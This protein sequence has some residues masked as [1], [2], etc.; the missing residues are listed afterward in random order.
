M[1]FS[2][3]L[4]ITCV[5]APSLRAATVRGT[6][7]DTSAAAVAGATVVLEN[8]AT[9]ERRS[10]T[11]GGDGRFAFEALPTGSY[12]LSVHLTGFSDEARTFSIGADEQTV[13]SRLTLRLGTLATSVTVTAT[14]SQRDS[15]IVPLRA[16]VLGSAELDRD[17]PA[18]T[19]DF[20]VR[21]PGVSLVGNGPFQVRPRLRGLDSTRLLVLIDGERLNNARTATDRAGVEVGLVDPSD[22]ERVEIVSGSGSVL[23]GTDALSGTIN[24][25]TQSARPSDAWRVTGGV[26]G[27]YST[28]ENARRGTLRAGA[29]GKHVA[30]S[31]SVSKERFGDYH[32]GSPFGESSV[33]LFPGTL[34]QADT[35]DDNFPP[36][37]FRAFPDPFN[38]PFTRTTDLVPNS[39]AEAS[40]VAATA[41]VEPTASQTVT[42]RYARRHATDVG[43]PDFDPPIFFQGLR[44]PF[45]NLD[46]WSAQY[47]VR[48][49]APWFAGLRATAYH[50]TQDRKL[51]NIGI[52][53]QFPVPTPRTFFPINVFR[54]L[55][56]TS[57]RQK[58]KTP[59]LDVQGTFL[60]SPRNVLIAG[61]T[62][63]EDRSDDSR[64]STTG[65]Y[66]AGNVSLG[67]RGPQANVFPEP[68][69]LGQSP[70]TFP[71]RVPD[72]TLR[73]IGFFVQDEWDLTPS[74][75]LVAGVRLDE[76][77]VTTEPTP[78]YDVGPVIGGAVPAIDQSTLPDPAGDRISRTAFTG[79]VGLVYKINDRTSF[80]AHYG[81][82]YRHP[83]LEE[84]LFAG[85]ATAGSI[86]PNIKVEP[87]KGDN[88]DFGVKVRSGR[89]SEQITYFRNTYR[90]LI[91]QEFVARLPGNQFLAQAV[92]FS[93]VRIQ[94]VEAEIE[95][96][97]TVGGALLTA[98]AS[99][100]YTHGKVIEA[101]NPLTGESLDGAPQD[102]ISPLK[103]MSGLRVSDR[104]GRVWAEYANRIQKK[105][106]RVSPLLTDSPFAIAQ[107]YLA[108][109][110]FT[111]HRL[112]AGIDWRAGG[113][114][115]G[116]TVAAE[117]IGDRFYREQFQFAPGRGR[118]FTFGLRLARR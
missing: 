80:L 35:I 45:S 38:S 65:T 89:V 6:V 69:F 107:D 86:A 4:A 76:Y 9:T 25:L 96:P 44:L 87:E 116:L 67:P 82:S 2:L 70:V 75:H 103:V 66:L 68:R 32:A 79:D 88:V 71:S 22:I 47:Q 33:A 73:D 34:Q 118:S 93:K 15:Q 39:A 3:C 21:A 57:T 83:N 59:G 20:L 81:R 85:P 106:E 95:A 41:V 110:G 99:G 50:Q 24:I 19:G 113:Y 28:N 12:R 26:R 23:Y 117:N 1:R 111:L 72:A 56:D 31:V 101:F 13:E 5:L 40:N 98:F 49:L 27:Y 53:V 46:K 42:L 74:L 11:T 52:P 7:S 61:F 48:D 30:A 100:A 62:V 8:V 90:G 97:F 18:S 112:A 51:E 78:G 64:T 94:G 17:N 36:F 10:T 63:Y 14:R 109:G 60:L 16:D 115:A 54:L 91:S 114:D 102:N 105:V 84:L 108:L 29:S 58:V 55:I 37:R 92:N 77:R 43:F 104:R